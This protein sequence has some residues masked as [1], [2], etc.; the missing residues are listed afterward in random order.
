MNRDAVVAASSPGRKAGVNEYE[1]SEPRSVGTFD[2]RSCRRYA[3]P[4][5]LACA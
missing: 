3:A 2:S 4:K 1:F 5:I